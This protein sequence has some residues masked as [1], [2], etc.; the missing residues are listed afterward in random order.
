MHRA[1]DTDDKTDFAVAKRQQEAD[2][3]KEAS[4]EAADH[5]YLGWVSGGFRV[6]VALLARSSVYGCRFA[7]YVFLLLTLF[8]VASGAGFFVYTGLHLRVIVALIWGAAGSVALW[9]AYDMYIH[10]CF[11]IVLDNGLVY[12]IFAS[13]A[14]AHVRP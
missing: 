1:A 5:D 14:V 6:Q 8:S 2:V 12:F 11:Q 3:L 9:F 4:G 10:Y 7:H 13:L